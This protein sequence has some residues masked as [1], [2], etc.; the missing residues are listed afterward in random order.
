MGRFV[1]ETAKAAQ[2][3]GKNEEKGKGSGHYRMPVVVYGI[4]RMRADGA[5][6]A[7][8]NSVQG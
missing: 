8:R 3:W 7:G 5:N 2:K 4:H 1:A 6:Q